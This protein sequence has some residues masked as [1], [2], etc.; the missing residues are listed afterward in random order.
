LGANER[1][2]ARLDAL[3]YDNTLAGFIARGEAL[4]RY[5]YPST[6]FN[7][8]S[9]DE[10]MELY[11]DALWLEERMVICMARGVAMAFGEK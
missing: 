4:A 1:F 2:Q 5:Y 7:R 10:F 9:V 3:K 11:A 6:D 8:L